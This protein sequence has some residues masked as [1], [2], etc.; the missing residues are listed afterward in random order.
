VIAAD[1]AA[2][3]RAGGTEV[4]ALAEP[5]ALGSVGAFY[6]EFPQVEEAEV[7]ALLAAAG[8]G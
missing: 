4:V 2:R 5:V 8:G 6:E 3:F 1:V 7:L